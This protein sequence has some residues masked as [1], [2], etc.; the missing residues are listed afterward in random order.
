MASYSISPYNEDMKFTAAAL[1]HLVIAFVVL[2]S[3]FLLPGDLYAVETAVPSGS[4]IVQPAKVELE[5]PPGGSESR[6]LTLTNSTAVPLAV[7]V[8]F[9]DVAPNTQSSAA[10]D[11][12][13][14][15]G[16]NG[17]A[18]PLRDLVHTS[19]ASLTILAGQTQ[20]VPVTVKIPNDTVPGGHY[21][22]VVFSF[23][24]ILPR[25]ISTNGNVAVE[26]RLATLF[27][28]RVSGAVK[29]EGR[30][31]EFGV[32][33]NA[34]TTFAPSP[35]KPLRFQI[36]YTNSGNVHLNPYGKLSLTPLFGKS[37]TIIVDPWAVLPGG[38]RMREIE[39]RE[40]LAIGYY[41][42]HLEQNRGYENIVD[43]R[44]VHFWV[45][46]NAEQLLIII[47]SI[48]FLVWLIRK[49]LSLSKHRVS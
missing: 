26:S 19:A 15:L 23:T 36:V 46:P 47:L 27:F 11:P 42:A 31:S 49:S 4:F 32:F 14:L 8:S 29:E 30:V 24:P 2:I 39:V 35:E 18:Y 37:T 43:T 25:G 34:Q 41:T 20:S 33:N 12:V 10:D 44:D 3:P 7:T 17:G 45:L 5:I 40:P 9:E 22:S 16:A 28:V 1:P 13:V 48:L 21:G 38:V 6:A